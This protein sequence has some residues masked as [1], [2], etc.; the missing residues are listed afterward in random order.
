M[1]ETGE[2]K[3][4]MLNQLNNSLHYDTTLVDPTS[5]H[6]FKVKKWCE[7]WLREGHISPKIADWLTDIEPRPGTAFGNVKTH[8]QSNPLRLI[9]SCCDT[10]IERLSAFTEFFLQPLAQKL[11]SFIKDT[12]DLLNKIEELNERGPLPINT[13]LVSWDVVAMF[14][15]IDNNL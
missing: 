8:K 1:I 3:E 15:N 5:N 6:M 9:T 14:P 12:T 2:Y 13:L 11:P 10:A 7:K 4:K